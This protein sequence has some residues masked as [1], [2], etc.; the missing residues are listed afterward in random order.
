ME[1]CLGV[2]PSI[3]AFA[4][5]SVRWLGRTPKVF[6]N[7]KDHGQCQTRTNTCSYSKSC[8][9]LFIL[10]GHMVDDT[11]V[12]LVPSECK[13]DILA[14]KLIALVVITVLLAAP[15]ELESG[16]PGPKPDVLPITPQR[17]LSNWSHVKCPPSRFPTTAA[18]NS[19]TVCIV[20]CIA[21][22]A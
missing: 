3:Y 20:H 1:A 13:S 12:E 5:R 21:I 14:T 22:K 16:I 19:T 7:V 10:T 4:E 17:Y 6:Q 18:H 8:T 2:A 11:R 9:I 15:P